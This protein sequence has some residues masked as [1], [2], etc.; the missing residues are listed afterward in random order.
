MVKY[1]WEFVERGILSGMGFGVSYYSFPTF[2]EYTSFI[3]AKTNMKKH[4]IENFNLQ[5]MRE[6][7]K[8]QGKMEEGTGPYKGT[9]NAFSGYLNF[10]KKF[11]EKM[12]EGNFEIIDKEWIR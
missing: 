7:I 4:V 11:V 9:F 6:F 10:N 8:K 5:E 2:G 3:D 12:K 1:N